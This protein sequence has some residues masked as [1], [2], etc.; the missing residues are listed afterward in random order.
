[1][2]KAISMLLLLTIVIGMFAGCVTPGGTTTQPTVNT[3]GYETLPTDIK[4]EHPG[5]L[6]EEKTTLTVYT[7]AG[8]NDSF[9]APSNDLEFWKWLEEYTNVHIEWEVVEVY[10]K[11][12]EEILKPKLA[13]GEGLADIVMTFNVANADSAGKAGVLTDLSLYWDSCFTKTQAYMNSIGYYDNYVNALTSSND[14]IYSVGGLAN[15]IEGH[16]VIMYNTAWM[17]ELG[18]EIPKTLDEFT[19]VLQA[20]KKAGDL[21]KNGQDDEVILTSSSMYNNLMGVLGNAFGLEQYLAAAPMVLGEDGKVYDEFRTE[22]YKELIRYMA[23]LYKQGILDA[24]ITTMNSNTLTQKIANQRVGVMIDWSAQ[25]LV[26]E[27]M[28]GNEGDYGEYYTLGAPLASKWNNNEGYFVMRNQAPTTPAAVSASSKN[29]E[30]ACMWLD[31]LLSDPVVLQTRTYGFEGKNYK[32]NDAGEIE[33][34]MPEDGSA[35]NVQEL[36][37]GQIALPFIQTTEQLLASKQQYPWY[38][39]QYA[40]LRD[41]YKWVSTSVNTSITL[42]NDAETQL[43]TMVQAPTHKAFREWRDKVIIGE[44]DLDASYEEMLANIESLGI[45]AWVAMWQSIVDRM[46]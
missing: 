13:V 24:E 44:L 38:L 19:A 40:D 30:L 21:N 34:I 31:T 27:L 41:N 36:G 1:M 5:W 10:G 7:Y 46:K 29:K 32:V 20:M 14:A 25:A 9:P 23:D 26:G 42:W 33:L 2:K 22:N 6:C 43:K 12:Y 39:E 37:C 8:A 16:V 15:P 3:G 4:D 17:K 35:W 28:S 45:D 11:D 18:L